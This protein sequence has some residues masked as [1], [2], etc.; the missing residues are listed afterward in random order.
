MIRPARLPPSRHRPSDTPRA[1]TGAGPRHRRRWAEAEGDT[2]PAQG[3]E[4]RR[5]ARQRRRLGATAG[6][7][8]PATVQ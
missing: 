4:P 1:G 2:V 7:R 3:V 6:S 8:R 5:H